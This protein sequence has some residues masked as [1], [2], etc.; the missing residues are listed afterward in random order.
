MRKLK[1]KPVK[2]PKLKRDISFVQVPSRQSIFAG[3]APFNL[4][5]STTPTS[6]V[7]RLSSTSI[8]LTAKTNERIDCS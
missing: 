4:A 7:T 8:W 6:P 5:T 3:G 1:A 2:V